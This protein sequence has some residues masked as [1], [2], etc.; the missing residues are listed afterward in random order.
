MSESRGPAKASDRANLSMFWVVA[1]ACVL[2]AATTA[3][4]TTETLLGTVLSSQEPATPFEL[5]DQFGQPV[6][7]ADYSGR[8]VVLTFL[9][10][11]CPDICPVATSRLQ[12]AHRML[13]DDTD[14]VAFVAISVDPGRDTVERAYDYS[15]DWDMLNKWAF[16]TGDE[17]ELSRIWE[18]YYIDPDIDHGGESKSG[19]AHIDESKQ[20]AVGSLQQ[21]VSAGYEIT[22][23]APVYVIDRR[24]RMRVLFT[25]PLDPNE[26]VH[27]IRLLLD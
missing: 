25:P 14:Q 26:L 4:S 12:E 13:G 27:D 15:Q 20:G 7:L 16:L 3:C 19:T 6:A 24:G 10:T 23:S 5:R 11:Y 22:H 9:Y 1:A 8:V 21:P 18:A 17:P 2:A